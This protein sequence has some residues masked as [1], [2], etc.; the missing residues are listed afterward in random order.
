MFP[1]LAQELA[2]LCQEI[3]NLYGPTETTIWSAIYQYSSDLPADCRTVPIGK[4][5]ANTQ[6]Y[7]LDDQLQLVPPGTPGELYIGGAGLARGY[8]NRPDLTAERFIP[9][10]FSPD[11]NPSDL[12]YKTGDLAKYLPDGNLECLGRLDNQVKIRGFR[13]ELGEIEAVLNQHPAVQTTVVIAKEQNLL[14]YYIPKSS[15]EIS[16]KATVDF[17]LWLQAKL[18]SYMIPSTI[19]S[20]SSFPLTPNGKID[21]KA[22]SQY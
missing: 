22:L 18:P 4:A 15:S 3:W 16:D 1:S 13:I 21:R 20:M 5:I 10:P 14:A 7:I 2:P 6:F 17:R 12:L 11:S 19:T 8:L 9:N